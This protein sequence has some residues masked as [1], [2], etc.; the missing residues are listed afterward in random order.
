MMAK[1]EQVPDDLARVRR[2]LARERAVDRGAWLR[3]SG[4]GL[5]AIAAVTVAAYAYEVSGG[6]RRDN[7]TSADLVRDLRLTQQNLQQQISAATQSSQ[8]EAKRLA[9]AVATL[10]ADRDRL[11][12]RVSTLEQSLD[13][14]TGSLSRQAAALASATSV[15]PTAQAATSQPA[16]SPPAPEPT[17]APNAAPEAMT[18]LAEIKPADAPAAVETSASRTTF[19]VDLGAAPNLDGLRAI[20]RREAAAST[21]VASLQP[22][23]VVRDR[24]LPT[25]V[26]LHLLAGPLGD[27]A[28]AAKLCAS[29][30]PREK[31]CAPAVYEGQRLALDTAT[32]LPPRKKPKA[33]RPAASVPLP[34][35]PPPASQLR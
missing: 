18:H 29:L 17:A 22:V 30:G 32:P 14:V 26:A 34:V 12:T 8:A 24:G 15:A 23:V 10:N 5:S 13:S 20:W 4:W 19:G 1:A 3:M 9:A 7:A 21:V 27:A 35:P 25:G 31:A 16:T 33:V 28:A 11:Y 2:L 6:F